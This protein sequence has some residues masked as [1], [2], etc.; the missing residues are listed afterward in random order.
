[1]MR[2]TKGMIWIGL[3]AVMTGSVGAFS[4]IGPLKDTD[5]P[6]FN[7]QGIDDPW[8]GAPYGGKPGGIGY[9][10]GGDIGGPM[11]P[12]EAYRWNVPVLTYAYDLTFL[13]YFGTNG[14]NA[15]EEAIAILNALPPALQMTATLSEFPF[16]TKAEN[17]TAGSLGL[18]DLKSHAL[19]FLVEEMGLANPER[20]VWGLRGRISVPNIVTNY[21]V[22]QQ[23]Y[24]PLTIEPSRYVNGVLYNYIIHDDLGLPSYASAVEWYQL[25]PLYQAYS[26]VAGG[27]GSPDLQLGSSP[28]AIAFF[29]GGLLPGQYFRGLT[30]DDAGGL[31]FLLSPNNKVFETLL[32]TILPSRGGTGSSPWSP[33]LGTNVLGTNVGGISNIIGSIGTNFPNFVRTA[34]RPGVDKIRFQRVPLFGT[35]FAP[36]IQRY[37]DRFYNPTN[38]R[39]MKQTVERIVFVPDIIFDVRDLGAPGEFAPALAA[40]TSTAGWTN[41]AAVNSFLGPAG[42]GGPGNIAPP[43]VITFGDM[44]P[45]FVN[46]LAGGQD[47]DGVPTKLL[48]GSF[49][50]TDRPPVVYPAFPHPLAPQLSLDY[51]RRVVLRGDQH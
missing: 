43:I 33:V 2:L 3:L 21:S 32:P 44:V 38:G 31:R 15:V 23:N 27:L 17:Q 34:Y 41:N 46:F 51:L 22:I 25:D 19:S 10:L 6:S 18:L 1:M 40:R 13:Q 37:T 20:F 30:R 7:N 12:S 14:V 5:N 50:G 45:V 49:D 48:W 16:D 35:N 24:D 26:S 8:Q 36:F 42:L 39:A 47:I 9:G 28:D 4:L 29:G 11:L